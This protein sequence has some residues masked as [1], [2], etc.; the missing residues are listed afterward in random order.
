MVVKRNV[1]IRLRDDVC[2]ENLGST[3]DRGSWPLPGGN[4]NTA[5]LPF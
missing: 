3:R 4:L 1:A 2:N 5:L